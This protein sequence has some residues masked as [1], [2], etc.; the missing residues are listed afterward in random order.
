[1]LAAFG[2]S[3]NSGQCPL[4]IEA[5]N[6]KAKR[7]LIKLPSCLSSLMHNER[8]EARS[9]DWAEDG[10]KRHGRF[11]EIF[12]PFGHSFGAQNYP[13]IEEINV[14][15]MVVTTTTTG[16]SDQPNTPCVTEILIEDSRLLPYFP[17]LMLRSQASNLEYELLY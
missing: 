17:F 16:G 13:P 6:E 8:D 11:I 7:K 3:A 14:T 10:A 5:C 12:Y 2:L 4:V 15:V 1:M 9:I